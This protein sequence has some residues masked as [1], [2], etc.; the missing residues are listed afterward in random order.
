MHGKPVAGFA[1]V[2][3]KIYIYGYEEEGIFLVFNGLRIWHRRDRRDFLGDD[4]RS[5]DVCYRCGYAGMDGLA[6][7]R[8][9]L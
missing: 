8:A 9:F 1:L 5:M 2:C 3:V 4:G 6:T 7:V